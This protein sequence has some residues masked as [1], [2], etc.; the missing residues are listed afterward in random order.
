MP[1]V[2]YHG[3]DTDKPGQ[4]TC[5]INTPVPDGNQKW[6]YLHAHD[7][8]GTI[9]TCMVH[10]DAVQ[11]RPKIEATFDEMHSVELS[12][13]DVA[14]GITGKA[15]IV[16]NGQDETLLTGLPSPCK[17]YINETT[18]VNVPDGILA[19][20]TD[21]EATFVIAIDMWPYL[22]AKFV[23]EATK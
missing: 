9:E 22:E 6:T 2:F 10:G 21:Q 5:V 13:N 18:E 23:V 7:L 12:D 19:L 17:V 1:L 11:A 16:A 15:T 4:I 3:E 20:S 8:P 14:Q